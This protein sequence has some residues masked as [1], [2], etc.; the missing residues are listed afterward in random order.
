MQQALK[1]AL[2][3]A[4]SACRFLMSVKRRTSEWSDSSEG[5]GRQK[6]IPSDDNSESRSIRIHLHPSV[7]TGTGTGMQSEYKYSL[8]LLDLRLDEIWIAF[9]TVL[10]CMVFDI[11]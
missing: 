5:T 9:C 3:L 6:R 10:Y 11:Q 4:L 7:F 8:N 2:K 1:L